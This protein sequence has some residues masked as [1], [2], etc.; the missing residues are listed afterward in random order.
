MYS[1]HRNLTG[2]SPVRSKTSSRE[3]KPLS[4]FPSPYSPL[5]SVTCLRSSAQDQRSFSFETRN[6]P[7]RAGSF[8]TSTLYSERSTV[9]SLPLKASQS[10]ASHRHTRVCCHGHRSSATCRTLTLHWSCLFSGGSS[11][12]KSSRIQKS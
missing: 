8:S 9:E 2:S 6:S 1:W 3:P 5:V 10:T 7:R 4:P 11:S 12:V